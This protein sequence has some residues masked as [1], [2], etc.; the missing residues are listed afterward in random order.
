M[1]E[2]PSICAIR[3]RS[4]E[5]RDDVLQLARRGG[6]QAAIARLTLGSTR[7]MH[8][9]TCAF[10]PGVAW[11]KETLVIKRRTHSLDEAGPDFEISIGA[12]L[13]MSIA[14]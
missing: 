13:A 10:M 3:K 14:S 5:H 9:A 6:Q 4:S 2:P 11:S 7:K 8:S 1:L 12:R